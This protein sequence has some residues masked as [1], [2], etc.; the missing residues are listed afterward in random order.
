MPH[1]QSRWFFVSLAS[2]AQPA[3]A[4]NKKNTWVFTQMFVGRGNI[5]FTPIWQPDSHKTPARL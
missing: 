4:N 3:K 5:F 2:L 1:L